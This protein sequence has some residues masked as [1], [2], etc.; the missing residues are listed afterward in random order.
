MAPRTSPNG[1]SDHV[2]V[3]AADTIWQES[4]GWFDAR[5]HFSFD[6]YRDPEQTGVGALRVFND[7]RIV[8]GAEW[9]LHPHQDFGGGG[10]SGEF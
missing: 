6:R 4:G 10:A 9:P 5:W 1:S 2:L 7:D 3:R 8:G